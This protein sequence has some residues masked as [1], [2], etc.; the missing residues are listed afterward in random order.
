M[1][2]FSGLPVTELAHALAWYERLIGRPP[3]M[4]PHDQEATWQ[5]TDAASIYVVVDRVRAGR[6]LLTVIIADLDR[7]LAELADRG[8]APVSTEG[9]R[10]A[11][12][13]AVFTDP[14]GNRVTFGQLPG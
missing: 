12:R 9:Q 8:L 7:L 2:V 13:R 14:D 4:R 5:L 10:G 11:L 6:G 3:D 1:H